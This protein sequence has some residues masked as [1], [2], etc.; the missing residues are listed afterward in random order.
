MSKYRTAP[1]PSSRMPG[2]IPYIIGN[3]AAERFSFYG[4]KGILTIF[5]TK[6]LMDG[7]GD[8]AVMGPEQAKA[9]FH[10]FTFAVYFTPIFGGLIADIF[11]GKYLTIISLS[12]IYCFGH[13]ALAL[14]ET[15]L[16][17]TLG[18]TLIA[19]GAGGIKPCVSAHVGDQFGK[20]NQNLLERIFAW[21]YFS[22]NLGSTVATLLIPLL[23]NWYG[24]QVAFGVP[25]L[26]MLIA[27]IVFWMGRNKFVHIPAGGMKFVRE[28]FSGEGVRA[29][30]KLS[31]IYVFVAMFWALFDQTGS[32]WVLQAEQMNRNVLGI[33]L[34]SSQLQAANPILV[35]VMIPLFAYVVYPLVGR[36]YPLTPLRKIAIGFF[37]TVPAFAVPAW[38]EM[39][40]T[41]GEVPSIGWQVL[42]Y[43]ILTAAE[44]L[45]SITCLEFSYTQAPRK[46]KSFIMSLYLASVALGNLFTAAV[47]VFIQNP[48]GTSKLQG[49]DY[50]WFFTACMAGTAVLFLIVASLYRERTY[51]QEEAP[52]DEAMA[53]SLEVGTLA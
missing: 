14:D 8:L 46:M 21:F 26:L 30:L 32:A 38:I 34:L 4:M 29:A 33:E 16:G 52:P 31:I 18:L 41:S 27:T 3:E 6:Y 7:S 9:W 39:R 47:N 2:G 22:I 15:R 53:E 44:V 35:M 43:V 13:L 20:T 49:A 11:L 23:L 10:F 17:L 1:V 28:T 42:S 40:I 24:P 36:F 51:I 50:Y 45:I 25:G 48:D 12:I 37:I 19:I 5:M